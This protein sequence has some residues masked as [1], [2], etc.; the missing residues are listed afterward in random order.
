L[1]KD[2]RYIFVIKIKELDDKLITIKQDDCKE[3]HYEYIEDFVEAFEMKHLLSDVISLTYEAKIEYDKIKA[4][5]Y[6]IDKNSDNLYI[7]ASYDI[8]STV[9]IGLFKLLLST[10]GMFLRLMAYYPYEHIL[11]YKNKNLINLSHSAI[12][13]IYTADTFNDNLEIVC[14]FNPALI[15]IK[16]NRISIR[17]TSKDFISEKVTCRNLDDILIVELQYKRISGLRVSIVASNPFVIS[18]L[19]LVSE[20]PTLFL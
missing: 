12:R 20:M 4:L 10:K 5:S 15:D 11:Y 13:R 6:Y 17:I 18:R 7:T 9:H 2:L 1:S 3:Q 19:N 14:N 16:N 8:D